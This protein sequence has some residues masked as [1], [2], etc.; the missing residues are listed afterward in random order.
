MTSAK[1]QTTFNL[2]MREFHIAI[3]A[4]YMLTDRC[5][6]RSCQGRN[7]YR[8]KILLTVDLVVFTMKETRIGSTY[9]IVI[10]NVTA[11]RRLSLRIAVTASTNMA[12]VRL[13]SGFKPPHHPKPS[14]RHINMLLPLHSHSSKQSSKICCIAII[15]N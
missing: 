8:L 9:D 5:L 13:K 3:W 7:T 10:V 14:N 6:H 11:L 1:V 2:Y 4:V 15:Y 12:A